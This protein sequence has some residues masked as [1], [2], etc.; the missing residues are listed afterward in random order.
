MCGVCRKSDGFLFSVEQ[1]SERLCCLLSDEGSSTLEKLVLAQLNEVRQACEAVDYT[2][3]VAHCAWSVKA[4][5]VPSAFVRDSVRD[6]PW[7]EI[8]MEDLWYMIAD[9]A[10][11]QIKCVPAPQNTAHGKEPP[12]TLR[13]LGGSTRHRLESLSSHRTC[14]MNTGS[15]PNSGGNGATFF[16]QSR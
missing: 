1:L 12:A 8:L 2:T 6:A 16:H 5:N 3:Y 4:E 11:V 10:V 7:G 14:G 15:L 13:R 9:L